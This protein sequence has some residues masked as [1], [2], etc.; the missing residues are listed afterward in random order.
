MSPAGSPPER[1]RFKRRWQGGGV[2]GLL[3]V[4]LLAVAAIWQVP[5]HLDWARYHQAIATFAASRIGRPVTIGGPVHLALLPQPELTAQDVTLADRGDGISAQIGALRLEVAIWPLL[6]GR[7]VP[8]NLKMDD[9]TVAVPWPLPR[10][11]ARGALPLA[12]G[13][14]AR[15]EGGTLRL[16]AVTLTGIDADI[17]ADPD[18]G[19]FS[20]AGTG[21]V[22]GHEVHLSA[23]V[24]APGPSGVAALSLTLDGLAR[25]SG[26]GATF[27]GRILGDGAVQGALRGNGPDLSMLLP[28]PALPWRV[29][30][31]VQAVEGV[32]QA[33]DLLTVL[34]DSPGTA[35]AVLRLDAPA[36]LD[37]TL[38]IGQVPLG[39]WLLRAGAASAPLRLHFAMQA[40]AAAALGGTVRAPHIAFSMDGTRTIIESATAILPGG[41]AVH[42]SGAARAVAGGASLDGPIHLHAPDLHATMAWLSRIVPALPA[43]IAHTGDADADMAASPAGVAITHLHGLIDGAAIAGEARFDTNPRPH[44]RAAITVDSVSMQK[45]PGLPPLLPEAAAGPFRA[46]DMDGTLTIGQ[47]LLPGVRLSHVVVAGSGDRRGL[48]I[49]HLSA[50]VQ[51]GHLEASGRLAPDGT[52]AA[53][54]LNLDAADAST[55]PAAWRPMPRLWQGP[56][57]LA[58][59]AAGPPRAVA[60]QFRCDVG[61][62]RAE[63]DGT[64]DA[65]VA[66]LTGTATLRHPGAPRLLQQIGVP[67]A[68]RW[69]GQGSVALVAHLA[70]RPGLVEVSDVSLAA[71]SLR[72]AGRARV[73]F[74]GAV[75]DVTASIEAPRLTLPSFDPRGAVP[76]PWPVLAGWQGRMQVT[77]AQTLVDLRPVASGVAADLYA[78]GGLVFAD[79]VTAHIAGGALRGTAALDTGTP[80]AGVPMLA[81]RGDIAGASPDA[82]D[83]RPPWQLTEGKADIAFDLT[84]TGNSPAAFLATLDGTARGDLLGARVQGIDLPLVTALL[85]SRSAKLRGALQ[86]ALASGDTGPVSGAVAAT[87]D[88]GAITLSAPALA[89]V[90]GRV[91]LAGT[92]DLPGQTEDASVWLQPAVIAPPTLGVRT[93]GAWQDPRRVVDVADALAWAG[94]AKKPR[95][96]AHDASGARRGPAVRPH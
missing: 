87:F 67:D 35:H 66:S 82:M 62:L 9:P 6:H 2:P 17:S 59:T 29:R 50:D 43:D 57:N 69:L 48:A 26:T 52:V 15:L 86:A 96:T 70:V 71:A 95:G 90:A 77:A 84:A 19:A 21:A 93:V 56:L 24:G 8:L 61:D 53:A 51:G 74:S 4:F 78:G 36:R 28:A 63:A 54:A 3:V 37:A 68:G 27:Q 7:L 42:F 88:H 45:F 60:A 89:G 34:G 91:A 79:D 55:L 1:H 22:G 10:V 94:L 11:P 38:S 39:A 41:A 12:P 47:V 25:L 64:V 32:V 49:D 31:Q 76:I 72:L 14:D 75:P 20:A 81:V 5:P 23:L 40:Q 46:V 83:T 85:A 30:G 58:L 92:I 73:D 44:L 13:F 65:S 80:A 16:G 33:P 18:T